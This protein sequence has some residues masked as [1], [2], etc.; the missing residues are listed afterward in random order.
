[1]PEYVT[2]QMKIL[3]IDEVMVGQALRQAMSLPS[4]ADPNNSSTTFTFS[5][6]HT[7]QKTPGNQP[8]EIY[9]AT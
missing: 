3:L 4:K 1:M 8:L 9:S 7:H 5:S 2:K 6:P